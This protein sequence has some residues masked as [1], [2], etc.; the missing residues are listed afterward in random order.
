MDK[1]KQLLILEYHLV[2]SCNL[3]CASCSHYS[4]LVERNT[5][6]KLDKLTNDLSLLKNKVGDNL[7]MLRLL[8][9]EP[10]LHPQICECLK[11]VR[12]LF[13]NA[14]ILLVT[15]GLMLP[16]MAKEFYNVC[17]DNNIEIAITDYLLIDFASTI[18]N[19]K[20]DGIKAISYKNSKKWKY[21]QLRLTEGEIDCFEKCKLKNMCNNYKDGKIYL[22]PHIAYID[23]FNKAFKKDIRLDESDY[24]SL[25]DVN[26]Y[27]DL[28]NKLEN[29]KPKFCFKYC[30]CYDKKHPT[31]GDWKR[32][33]KDI[34]EFCEMGKE[35]Q[36]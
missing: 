33:K 2:D 34:E 8:G 31:I 27:D 17:R 15:N 36:P 1:K 24:I 30:N 4:S 26:D 3:N 9:G 10:L 16:K 20:R 21:K 19:L 13:P 23:F 18:Y 29:A 25:G 14:K 12:N 11:V 22:C 7:H 32:T 35:E 6:T 28:M 5:Y